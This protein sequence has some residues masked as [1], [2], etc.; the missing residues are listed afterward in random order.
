MRVE[1]EERI[2]DKLEEA[3]EKYLAT[4]GTPFSV[5]MEDDWSA[6]ARYAES[7]CMEIL[8]NGSI[9]NRGMGCEDY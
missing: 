2:S 3:V 1:I 7:Q 6:I 5:V 8:K 9:V 4:A